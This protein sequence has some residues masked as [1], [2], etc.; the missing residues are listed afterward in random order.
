MLNE[1]SF[2]LPSIPLSIFLVLHTPYF[3]GDSGM[4]LVVFCV[5]VLPSPHLFL[6]G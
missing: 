3:L 6:E 5:F 2:S 4:G 1:G